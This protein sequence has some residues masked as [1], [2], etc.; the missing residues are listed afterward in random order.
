MP[1]QS[2]ASMLFSGVITAM[3]SSMGMGMLVVSRLPPLSLSLPPRE[4]LTLS[5]SSST[6][7]DPSGHLSSQ[8]GSQR[9]EA[10]T[11]NRRCELN[12]P[13]SFRRSREPPPHTLSSLLDL[14]FHP[15]PL[16][17]HSWENSM[18]L[19]RSSQSEFIRINFCSVNESFECSNKDNHLSS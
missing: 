11:S 4:S 14:S 16:H 19:L 2:D 12:S 7:P 5:I 9:D 13:P 17:R 8:S 1:H 3:V 15:G 6:H 10:R 18:R